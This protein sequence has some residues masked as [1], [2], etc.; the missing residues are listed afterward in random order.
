MLHKVFAALRSGLRESSFREYYGGLVDR[1]P[2]V[3]PTAA[4]A[5]RVADFVGGGLDVARMA[6]AVDGSLYRN[7]RTA[8]GAVTS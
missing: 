2:H 5:R 4:E 6:G 8:D 7:R 1:A 3:A